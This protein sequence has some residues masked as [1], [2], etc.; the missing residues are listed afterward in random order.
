MPLR[1]DPCAQH[2]QVEATAKL[3]LV[4][5]LQIARR[6]EILCLWIEVAEILNR[7]SFYGAR[8]V[9]HFKDRDRWKK[10]PVVWEISY[11]S[12]MRRNSIRGRISIYS[13]NSLFESLIVLLQSMGLSRR[14]SWQ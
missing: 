10:I 3:G 7:G 8:K 12:V 6:W 11:G 13:A 1:E 5:T 9:P 4:D 14:S 2:C